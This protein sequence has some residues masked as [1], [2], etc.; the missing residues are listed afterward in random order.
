MDGKARFGPIALPIPK[1]APHEEGASV[2]L[3]SRPE[4]VALSAEEPKPDGLVLGK[5]VILEHAFSGTLR[6]VRLRL[7]RLP[8]TR[9]VAPAAAFGEEGLLVDAVVPTDVSLPSDELWV[10]LQAWTILEQAPPRLLVLDTGSGPAAPLE[11]A[12]LLAGPM[13]ASIDI[14]GFSVGN[15]SEAFREQIK[16]CAQEAGLEETVVQ[17]G[18]GNLAQQIAA[19]CA[20]ALFE[21]VILPGQLKDHQDGVDQEVI[22]FLQRIDLPVIVATGQ[23][24]APISRILICTRAGEPGKSDIRFGGRLARHL[25]ARVTLLHVTRHSAEPPPLVQ[26]HLQQAS[27]TLS[28]LEVPNEVVIRAQSNP[29]TVIIREA[30]E[31]DLVVIGGHGPQ[32]RSL[33]GRDD[34]TIQVLNRVRRPVLVVPSEK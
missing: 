12:R 16:R 28:G 6:R 34:V 9:Q 25:G 2:E 1:D 15:A 4:Q 13:R 8:A 17:V 7:P 14:M 11:L 10:R 24:K 3:L 22:S 32:A 26:R 27:A 19:Q 5:G 21:L 31:H 23:T 29:A 30:A 18:S 33:F 20:N